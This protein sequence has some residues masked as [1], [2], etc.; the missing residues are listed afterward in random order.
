MLFF[1]SLYAQNDPA[2][3]APADERVASDSVKFVWIESATADIF[4]E[5][6][7]V[8]Y[9]NIYYE[10]LD[11]ESKV[12]TIIL[13]SG[14]DEEKAA[15]VFNMQF[16]KFNYP[17]IP[18][19]EFGSQLSK[20]VNLIIE[21]KAN[22]KKLQSYGNQ[23]YSIKWKAG[24]QNTVEVSGSSIKG[25]IYGAASLSQLVIKKNDK[26]VLRKANVDD[27][28]KFSRRIFNSNPL[29]SHLQNDL[30]WMVRFKI[31]SLSFHNKD[32]SWNNIDDQLKKN[33]EI[34]SEWNKKFGGVEALLMLNLYRGEQIEISNQNDIEKI[35]D[36]IKTAYKNGVFRIMILSDDSPPFRF[37]EGYVSNSESDRKEFS[38]MA[39]S[40]CV[41]MNELSRWNKQLGYNLELLY[42]PAFYTYQEMHYGEMDLYK[43]TP[44]EDDAYGPF[45]RD[46]KIIGE[47]MSKDVSIIWTGPDVCSRIITD[48]DLF[49]WTNNLLGRKPFLFDNSIFAQFEFTART[50]FTAYENN[51]PKDFDLKTGGNGIFINGDGVGETSKA[52]TMTANAYMWEGDRY[53]PQVSLIN[54]MTKLYGENSLNTLL[55]Y[56]ETELELVK[57]IKQRELWEA[58]DELWKSIRKTRFI[59]EKNPFAYHLNYSRLKA[60]KMQLKCSVPEP[61]SFYVFKSKC[62]EFDNKRWELIKEIERLSFVRLSY[63]LQTEMVK[64]PDFTSEQ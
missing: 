28:P 45:K 4:P 38:T 42:C 27:Y 59:T 41:L 51:F 29:P 58:S 14:E 16:A 25:L 36:V 13:I 52:A 60:L 33:M 46:L 7:N 54:A 2:K 57:T 39:E 10:L 22:S 18:V 17:Q 49:D 24:L 61:E 21:L 26:I 12:K 20:D 63:A 23:A 50:M 35:K 19:V 64:L 53:K 62:L 32:Y 55:K 11:D 56:K 40:H 8:E 30:D 34:F 9:S 6:V 44:W 31:E 15:N 37:G 43:D 3:P 48:E 5:P 47:K 1:G